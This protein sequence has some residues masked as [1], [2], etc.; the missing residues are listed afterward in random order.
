MSKIYKQILQ[1]C[2]STYRPS[3]VGLRFSANASSASTR[4]ELWSTNSYASA[5]AAI[6]SHTLPCTP[7]LARMARFAARSANGAPCAISD[8][9]FSARSYAGKTL[10]SCSAHSLNS[11]MLTPSFAFTRRPLKVRSHAREYPTTRLRR[12][13]PPAPG[14]IPRR[15]SGRATFASGPATRRSH[16]SA[17]SSPPPSATPSSAAM[18]GMGR[19]SMASVSARR[20]DTNSRTSSMDMP[21]L[22]LRSA[23]AQ[24]TPGTSECRMSTRASC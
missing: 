2:I 17:I 18:V 7:P 9:I 23:P 1:R 15:T 4:S 11:P 22:S 14:M 5:S 20:R 8:A 6:P 19:L 10:A 13:V 24:K 21:F 12:C 16:A 3:N